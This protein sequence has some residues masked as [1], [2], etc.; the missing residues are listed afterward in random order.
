MLPN[1]RVL[2][3]IQINCR[4]WIGIRAENLL[5]SMMK[6]KMNHNA[7]LS[8]AGL[9][10]LG[11]GCA[12]VALLLLPGCGG[13]SNVKVGASGVT[14][15]VPTP[16]T[17]A[18]LNGPMSALLTNADGFSAHAVLEMRSSSDKQT[19]VSGQLLG[20]GG[21]LLFAMEPPS[22]ERKRA[23]GFSYIWDV[24]TQSGFLLSDPMQGYAPMLSALQHTNVVF[25]PA[26]GRSGSETIDGYRCEQVVATVTSSDGTTTAYQVWRAADLKGIPVRIIPVDRPN[27]TLSLS[28]I[29]LEA[30][31]GQLFLPPGDFTRFESPDAMVSE[32]LVRQAI[33]KKKK[34]SWRDNA[35][36]F[37]D[38]DSTM[39]RR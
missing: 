6:K 19:I 13:G 36:E 35:S 30:L 1:T 34:S 11:L 27:V 18:F 32:L 5:H 17:P 12:A 16:K 20:R 15:R 8:M 31:P 9:K 24:A 39:P 29:R 4:I 38:E 23:G 21:K 14:E 2:K 10:M 37:E 7:N 28:K 25:Q 3:P 33:S 26:P 22:G